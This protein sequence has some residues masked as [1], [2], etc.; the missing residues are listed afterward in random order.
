[1]YL[2]SGARSDGAE[3]DSFRRLPSPWRPRP[4]SLEAA[5]ERPLGAYDTR[6]AR[7]VSQWNALWPLSLRHN[8]GAPG[9]NNLTIDTTYN[10]EEPEPDGYSRSSSGHSRPLAVS[11]SDRVSELE[12]ENSRLHRLVAELLIKN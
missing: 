8:C 12:V 1:H 11:Y 10:G 2:L 4:R 9:M 5:H 3:Q 7:E 6:G